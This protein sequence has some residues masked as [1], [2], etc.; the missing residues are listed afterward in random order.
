MFGWEG[1]LAYAWADGGR[2][3]GEKGVWG[4]ATALFCIIAEGCTM[5]CLNS[6]HGEG[7]IP[8]R[9]KQELYRHGREKA[10]FTARG[11]T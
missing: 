11:K 8:N 9:S 10:G 4:W 6:R 7:R 3:R 1:C 5:N 2:K